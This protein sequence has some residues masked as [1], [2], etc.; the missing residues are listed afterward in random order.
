MVVRILKRGTPLSNVKRMCK[1]TKIAGKMSAKIIGVNT[2]KEN[3]VFT[4][5]KRL[6]L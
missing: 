2:E 3:G 5:R 1:S 4:I 6:K